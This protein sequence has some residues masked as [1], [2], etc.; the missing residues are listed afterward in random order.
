M[1]SAA[2]LAFSIDAGAQAL[3]FTSADYDPASLAAGGASLAQ[4]EDV[5]YAV[6]SNPAAVA[7]YDGTLDVS[8]GFSMWQP[9]SVNTSVISAGG[10]YKI[11]DR[12]GMALGFSSGSYPEYMGSDMTGYE[13]ESF[14]PSNMQLGLGF[15]WRV[16]P[17]VSVGANIGYASEKLTSEFSYGALDMDIYAMAEFGGLKAV[18]GVSEIGGKVKSASGAGFAL[19]SALN[20]GVGYG[21]SPVQKHDIS[22]RADAQYYFMGDFAA[23]IGAAYTYDDMV[24][25]RAGYR[26][27]G[28]SVIPSFMSLGAGVKFF[29]VKVDVAYVLGSSA[30][31]NT[32]AVSLGYSF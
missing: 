19:P 5:S 8:A 22:L 16:L 32:V 2:A 10:A 30:M 14:K 1:L 23:A 18:L 12:F 21:M 20:L 11:G 28:T 17:N 15:G 7:F 27:G 3:P 29:G 24:T 4:T 9:K 25:L 26:Y 6:F 31:A 13:T